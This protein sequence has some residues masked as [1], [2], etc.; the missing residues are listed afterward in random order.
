MIRGSIQEGDVITQVDGKACCDLEA[1]DAETKREKFIGGEFVLFPMRR[2]EVTSQVAL[3]IEATT[4]GIT[5]RGYADVSLR[6]SGFPSV[7]SHDTIVP[8]QHCGG[9][10]VDLEGR[11]VGVNIARIHRYSTLAVPPTTIRP[12]VRELLSKTRR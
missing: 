4:N 11:V 10:V 6:L 3:P 1:Y 2:N 12:L 8:R 9:P 7:F 5:Y